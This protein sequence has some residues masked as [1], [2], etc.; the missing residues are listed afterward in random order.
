MNGE[1]TRQEIQKS[2][3][4]ADRVNFRQTYLQPAIEQGFV[5]MKFPQNPNHPKQRYYLTPKGIKQ[6]TRLKENL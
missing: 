4:L 2:L 5:A 1:M 3:N 6:K